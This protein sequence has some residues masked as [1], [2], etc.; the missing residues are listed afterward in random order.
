M[1]AARGD[2]VRPRPVR[3]GTTQLQRAPRPARARRTRP[4]TCLPGCGRSPRR[5]RRRRDGRRRW[6]CGPSK[7]T[8]GRGAERGPCA[9]SPGDRATTVV[10]HDNVPRVESVVA[11]ARSAGPAAWAA[12]GVV[13]VL[14]G[15]T[16]LGNR[17]IIADVPPLFAG[18]ARFV[19]G[20]SLLAL[21]VLA[22]AGRGAF[23]MT[24]PQ[25]GTAA[26]SGLLLPAWGNGL[27]AV[28]QQYVASG[29]AALLIAAT[30]IYIVVL[31]ALTGDRPRPATLGGVAVGLL[32]LALLVVAGPSGGSGGTLGTTWWGPVA[33]AARGPGLGD[34]HVRD[35]PAA[36]PAQPVRAGR[37]A[38]AGGRDDPGDDKPGQRGPARPHRP[39]TDGVV[40]VGLHGRRR[41]ARGV[42]RVRVRADRHCRCPRSRPTPTST[43]SSPCCSG[44]WSWASG[45]PRCSSR[46]ARVVLVA[47]VLVIAAERPRKRR[48]ELAPSSP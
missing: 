23:R 15:S 6:P 33:D 40:G 48:G 13:Y 35:H 3:L 26:L 21:V 2:G 30:P 45:S 5:P 7:P 44:C 27:V 9:S 20:G 11:P 4:P 38:D 41:V 19:V 46:G 32:G 8:P 43:R 47:V 28:G 36:G 17:L 1:T 22:A 31:R 12:L 37:H 14:W 42:Q 25:F 24:A 29:M 18:G 10:R 16:Y 34:G 39:D